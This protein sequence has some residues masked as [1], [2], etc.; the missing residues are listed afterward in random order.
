VDSQTALSRKKTR[1]ENIA[2]GRPTP[3]GVKAVTATRDVALIAVAGPGIIGCQNI[4]AR[5]FCG[6]RI[7]S[8][9][10]C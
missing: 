1:H 5:I 4:A 8:A 6:H 3:L 7:G 2:H 10:T 9:P